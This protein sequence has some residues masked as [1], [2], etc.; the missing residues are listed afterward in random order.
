MVTKDSESK[1]SRSCIFTGV[2]SLTFLETLF[3]AF[4]ISSSV[5]A[6]I[7]EPPL[8]IVPLIGDILILAFCVYSLYTYI[9]TFKMKKKAAIGLLVTQV[10]FLFFLIY[11]SFSL[12]PETV[13][14]KVGVGWCVLF[15]L[16]YLVCIVFVGLNLKKMN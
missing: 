16:L 12:K 3:M 6:S 9:G 1:N 10:V 14:Q 5:F 13:E 4:F 8:K 2:L 7:T 15:I 11:L